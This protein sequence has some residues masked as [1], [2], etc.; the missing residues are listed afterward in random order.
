MRRTAAV[1]MFVALILALSSCAGDPPGRRTDTT[2]IPTCSLVPTLPPP[3]D[4]PPNFPTPAGVGY[5]SVEKAGPST[6][7][8]GYMV[9]VTLEDAF[10]AWK[11]AFDVAGYQ[12]TDEEREEF[13][14]EV[15]FAGGSSTG[16]VRLNAG[17]CAGS[18]FVGVTIRPGS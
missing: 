4:L 18:V 3:T 16:Q 6:I 17:E 7:L 8:E 1:R 5:Y 2:P 13:D 15:N 11:R 14:A 12:V 9:A 10:A